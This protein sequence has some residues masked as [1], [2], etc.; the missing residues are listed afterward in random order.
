MYQEGVSIPIK[1]RPNKKGASEEAPFILINH[2]S[3]LLPGKRQLP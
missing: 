3:Y 2:F 1:N